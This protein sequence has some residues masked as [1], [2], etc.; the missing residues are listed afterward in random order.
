[1]SE[2]MKA[3]M[4]HELQMLWKASLQLSLHGYVPPHL[5]WPPR[6]VQQLGG[7]PPARDVRLDGYCDRDFSDRPGPEKKN[8]LDRVLAH[9]GIAPSDDQRSVFTGGVFKR[10]HPNTYPNRRCGVAPHLQR[11]CATHPH[12]T[13]DGV[14]CGCTFFLLNTKAQTLATARNDALV[15]SRIRVGHPATH[16]TITDSAWSATMVQLQPC[17]PV[18]GPVFCESRRK[19]RS[20]S[21]NAELAYEC[22]LE[23]MTS[24]GL[25]R[26]LWRCLRNSGTK[27]QQNSHVDLWAQTKVACCCWS[28]RFTPSTAA[29]ESGAGAHTVRRIYG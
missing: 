9:W 27:R 8:I 29:N 20:G 1:M 18:D 7:P 15:S 13:V 23:M 6:R 21:A 22:F 5:P 25:Y 19:S 14:W 2:A 28:Q 16:D 11:R 3:A 26:L 4:F 24:D 17:L 10:Y 12:D